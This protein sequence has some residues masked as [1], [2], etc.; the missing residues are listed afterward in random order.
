ML[1]FNEIASLYEPFL[2][3]FSYVLIIIIISFIFCYWTIGYFI[4]HSMALSD[5]LG[6]KVFGKNGEVKVENI[7]KENTI[8]GKSVA[9]RV[10]TASFGK[11][12][13]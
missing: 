7:S 4:P 13:P 1:Q 8:V 5:Q 6:D 2:V 9:H 10:S 12:L 3:D 11:S